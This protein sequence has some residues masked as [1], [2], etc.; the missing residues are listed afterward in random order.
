VLNS[1]HNSCLNFDFFLFLIC[2]L[3]LKAWLLR[4]NNSNYLWII[5]CFF[6]INSSGSTKR[7]WEALSGLFLSGTCVSSF[8]T[9]FNMFSLFIFSQPH[10]HRLY[11]VYLILTSYKQ[12]NLLVLSFFFREPFPKRTT[13]LLAPS[14][15]K[16][17]FLCQQSKN[18]TFFKHCQSK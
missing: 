13:L 14:S 18:S 2:H 7:D 4:I 15:L 16:T 12:M 3:I 11:L 9:L 17:P 8:Q 1:P 5:I 10:F 6:L